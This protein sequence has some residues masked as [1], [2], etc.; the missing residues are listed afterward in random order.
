MSEPPLIDQARYIITVQLRMS[1]LK[2]LDR[3]PYITILAY[4]AQHL[5]V[6]PIDALTDEQLDAYLERAQ[7]EL[8]PTRYSKVTAVLQVFRDW[9]AKRRSSPCP[10]IVVHCPYCGSLAPL[11]ESSR[12]QGDHDQDVHLYVCANY[13]QC[14]AYVSAYRDDHWPRGTL[15]NAELRHWRQQ[16]QTRFDRL[17]RGGALS[18]S[19]ADRYLQDLMGTKPHQSPI[20]AFT[21]E[22]CHRLMALLIEG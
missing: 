1:Q 11:S 3:D 14:D 21:L 2:D 13:P 7:R 18:R 12:V 4:V 9:K 16:A 5:G 17:W 8:D 10:G 22:Q 15:A 6:N 20:S 19:Q